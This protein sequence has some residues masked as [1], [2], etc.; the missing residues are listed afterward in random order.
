[1]VILDYQLERIPNPLRKKL[2]GTSGREGVKRDPDFE[3]HY[4]M[5]WGPGLSKE[6]VTAFIPVPA[7][8]HNPTPASHSCYRDVLRAYTLKCE[9][10]PSFLKLLAKFFVP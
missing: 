1:M 10:N 5:P 9:P 4:P 3:W 8:R 7:C 2:L 6:D